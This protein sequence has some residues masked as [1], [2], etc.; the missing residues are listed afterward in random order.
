[1]SRPCQ[2]G[3]QLLAC[4]SSAALLGAVQQPLPRV[5]L[6]HV[7]LVLDSAT[8]A[9]I[10]GSAFL[11]DTFAVLDAWSGESN[12]HAAG[13]GVALNGRSTYVE[14]RRP[15][16]GETV[17][18]TSRL[19]FGT[20]ERGALRAVETRLTSEA[21]ALVLDSVARKRDSGDVPWF[22]VLTTREARQDSALDIRVIEYHPQ[23]LRRW[24]GVPVGA[25]VSVARADALA[26]HAA[27]ASRPLERGRAAFL[28]VVAIKIAASPA[29]QAVLLS[30]CRGVGW[31]VQPASTGTACVGPGVRLFVVPARAAEHG[32]VAFTMRVAATKH[33]RSA[34]LRTFGRSTL[35]ISSNGFATWEFELLPG[36][37]APAQ[38][39]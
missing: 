18:W 21:G 5:G 2:R 8:F 15:G 26:Q 27:S 22:Y 17:A 14:F 35:R 24:Y 32:I 23:F 30:H 3:L 19:A 34:Q 28:D 12:G 1:M 39:R 10:A 25:R 20:D 16:N 31:R 11:R 7:A 9:A 36:S 6:N 33:V 38:S 13:E 29:T 37:V 4:L